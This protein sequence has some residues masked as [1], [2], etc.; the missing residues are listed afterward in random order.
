MTD[1]YLAHPAG[2]E[3]PAVRLAQLTP[4]DAA[5]LTLTTRAIA[6]GS[7]GYVQVTTVMGDTGRVFVVPGAPFPVRATR[8][9]ATGTT[10]TDI[11]GLA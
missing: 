8:I 10:A 2:L 1:L 7:E 5:D 4:N 3:S 6:V 9:W 11:V